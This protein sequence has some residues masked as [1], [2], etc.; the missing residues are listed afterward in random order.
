MILTD[1]LDKANAFNR[2]F[3]SV[4][5]PDNGFTPQCNNVE[6]YEM[7]ECIT[8]DEADVMSAIAKLKCSLSA[9]PDNLPPLARGSGER[10]KLPQGVWVGAP[11]EI[12]FGAF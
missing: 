4:G 2:Y 9:G 5:K 11:A 12:E 3:S 6:F 10:C 1:S 8:V 7:M